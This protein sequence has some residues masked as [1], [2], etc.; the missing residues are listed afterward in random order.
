MWY[1]SHLRLVNQLVWMRVV[2]QLLS[3]VWLFVTPWTAACQASLSFTISWNLLKFMSVKLVMPSNHLILCHPLLLPSIFPSLRVF[4][5]K[6]ALHIR[7]PKYWSFPFSISP[8][9]EYPAIEGGIEKL[10]HCDHMLQNALWKVCRSDF[11]CISDHSGLS[12]LL[13]LGSQSR[14]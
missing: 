9:T 4:S 11:S 8:S 1:P 6:S 7:W 2:V 13:R 10:V 14:P 3:R 12:P 5:N